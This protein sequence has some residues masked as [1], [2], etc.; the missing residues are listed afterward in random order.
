MAEKYPF[1]L[2][3][4]L[5]DGNAYGAQV[6]RAHKH[7]AEECQPAIPLGSLDFGSDATSRHLQAA[8]VVAWTV[9]RKRAEDPF[10]DYLEP[11]ETI[12]TKNHVYVRFNPEW[13][14]EISE[15]MKK[16]R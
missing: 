13:M 15:Q 11:L 12:F 1:E 6:E 8:D 3:Y 14:A 7:L 9:R 16:Q 2:P 4:I 10:R 5:D